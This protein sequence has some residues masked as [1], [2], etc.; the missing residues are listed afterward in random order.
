MGGDPR[1]ALS[2]GLGLLRL[3]SYGQLTVRGA[4]IMGA[5]LMEH[6]SREQ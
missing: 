6:L 5:V 1:H 4:I 2:A 3:S